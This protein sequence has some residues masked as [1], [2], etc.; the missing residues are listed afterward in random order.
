MYMVFMDL[1]IACPK[2]PYSLLDN[3][4][5]ID[6]PFGY[7]MLSFIDSYLGYNQICMDPWMHL[8]LPSCQTTTNTTT[9][10]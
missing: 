5:L 4:Y 7:R 10:S 2:D 9:T 6:G 3:D 8:K 1:N